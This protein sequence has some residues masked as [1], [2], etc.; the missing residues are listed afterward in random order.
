MQ[1]SFLPLTIT[2]LY[3]YIIFQVNTYSCSANTDEGVKAP[4]T[5]T[6][7]MYMTKGETLEREYG[8]LFYT[9]LLDMEMQYG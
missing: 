4:S 8:G 5:Y 1:I 2:T 3:S 9:L 7:C 6:I